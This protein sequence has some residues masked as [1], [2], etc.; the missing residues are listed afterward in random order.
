MVNRMSRLGKF[1]VAVAIIWFIGATAF[2]SH[3]TT[4]TQLLT[5]PLVP[6]LLIAVLAGVVCI[7][8]EWR[9][10]KWRAV[11]PLAACILS[12]FASNLFVRCIRRALFAYSLPS[13]EQVVHR[14]ESGEILVSTNRTEIPQAT[15]TAR[16]T[17]AVF[18]QKNTN[19][20]LTVEF[21]TEQGFPVKHSG[22]LYS[23]SGA[24]ERGSEADSH[25]PIRNQ[26]RPHW[27]YIS[28]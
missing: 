11:V 26:Q 21:M 12:I 4:V 23:S 24:I 8:T 19:G 9:N 15:A 17:W 1:V 13:Y 27:F 6:L 28:D 20:V 10:R 18:A 16:L 22:Y 3:R 14:I 25:W 7:F 5:L 2:G